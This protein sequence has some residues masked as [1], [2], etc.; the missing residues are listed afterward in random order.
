MKLLYGFAGFP[1]L[2]PYTE[3]LTR[4][5]PVWRNDSLH[6]L[7][8]FFFRGLFE[9]HFVVTGVCRTLSSVSIEVK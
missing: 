9:L 8:D 6:S 3:V 2:L 7:K 4:F 1:K 5:H